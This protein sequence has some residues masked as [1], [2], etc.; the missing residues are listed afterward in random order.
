MTYMEIRAGVGGGGVGG[1]GVSVGGKREKERETFDTMVGPIVCRPEFY[2]STNMQR[3][4]AIK[5][6]NVLCFQAQLQLPGCPARIRDL[7][8]RGGEQS[9]NQGDCLSEQVHQ[10]LILS[11][12]LTIYRVPVFQTCTSKLF[13]F[14]FY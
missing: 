8:L 1:V 5:P 3:D 4:S 9:P 6:T 11:H 13:L 7:V 14:G 2:I 10:S 12:G